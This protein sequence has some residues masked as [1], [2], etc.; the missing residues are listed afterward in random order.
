MTIWNNG[1]ILEIH[2]LIQGGKRLGERSNG[3]PQAAI[4]RETFVIKSFLCN[5][6]LKMFIISLK[7]LSV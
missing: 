2:L 1:S 4:L 5:Y 3:N 6:P 7:G